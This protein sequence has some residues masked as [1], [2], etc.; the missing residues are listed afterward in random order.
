MAS[1][2]V[3]VAGLGPRGRA[4]A[5]RLRAVGHRV[6]GYDEDV[7]SA[8]GSGLRTAG[9]A[10]GLAAECETVLVVCD[11]DRAESLIR[12]LQ[13][14]GGRLRTVALC[15]ALEPARVLELEAAGGAAVI[16]SPLDGDEEAIRAGKATVF[17]AGNSGVVDRCRL[18]LEAL[19]SV[20]YVGEAGSGQMAR[21]VNDLLR[22]ASVLAIHDAFNLV[23]A[24]GQ[25]PAP[26]RE[27]VLRASGAN[28]A[29]E[30]W[31]HTGVAAA[32]QDIQ[33]ALVLAQ[34]TGASMPFLDEMDA[35]V[36]RLDPEAMAGLFNL[37]IADLTPHES[38]ADADLEAPLP[39]FGDM[40]ALGNGL[41]EPDM[42]VESPGF[43]APAAAQPA[44]FDDLE[45]TGFQETE[46]ALA[47]DGFEDTEPAA[48]AE[49]FSSADVTPDPGGFG[50]DVASPP[51]LG[52]LEI[53]PSLA[54]FGEE[55]AATTPAEPA[56]AFREA[57]FPFGE[58]DA[59][60]QPDEEDIASD[61]G[62]AEP[63]R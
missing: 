58:A 3:G 53:E 6:L 20:V 15:G 47:F 1:S 4:I 33:A 36:A 61:F 11:G 59:G 37:G 17:A 34:E 46:P 45:V 10:R 27:A 13:D 60:L 43:A 19:G 38:L 50:D 30:E 41:E 8:T 9:T 21:T 23:R 57:E 39:I 42:D 62:E 35:L 44:V 51:A 48:A 5:Q 16:E 14:T 63:H 29:L 25:D 18:L 28:R 24:A 26:I 12:D 7:R 56:P 32:R 54:D 31:G 22:W 49:P 52:A 2:I 40:D 55:P